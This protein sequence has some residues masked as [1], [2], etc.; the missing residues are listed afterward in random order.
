MLIIRVQIIQEHPFE[1]AKAIEE[2][3]TRLKIIQ[4]IIAMLIIALGS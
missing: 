3:I 4:L 2:M 1:L